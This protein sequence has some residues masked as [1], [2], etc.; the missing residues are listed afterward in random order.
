MIVQAIDLPL[1]HEGRGAARRRF[2][3]NGKNV[4]ALALPATDWVG[5]LDP[6][7]LGR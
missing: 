4:R 1:G 7:V 5:A 6:R 2:A 3:D